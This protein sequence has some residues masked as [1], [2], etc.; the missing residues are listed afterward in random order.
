MQGGGLQDNHCL[1]MLTISHICEN[2]NSDSLSK[3]N[4]QPHCMCTKIIRKQK[5]VVLISCICSF[6]DQHINT[7]KSKEMVINFQWRTT[8]ITPV[9][10]QGSS[11]Q[12][13]DCSTQA[14]PDQSCSTHLFDFWNILCLCILFPVLFKWINKASL[15]NTQDFTNKVREIT[16]Y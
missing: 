3:H 9:K 1:F 14:P 2:P 6:V 10:I 8:L 15:E 11:P 12:P 16:L 7:S 4:L 5:M 13:S